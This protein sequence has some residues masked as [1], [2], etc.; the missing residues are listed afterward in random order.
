VSSEPLSGRASTTVEYGNG[1]EQTRRRRAQGHRPPPDARTRTRA[2]NA[3]VAFP[4]NTLVTGSVMGN[5]HPSRHSFCSL[6]PPNDPE[7]VR[8]REAGMERLVR[9]PSRRQ[10]S[11][12][13]IARRYMASD[14]RPDV[15]PSWGRVGRR[16][17]ALPPLY[18]ISRHDVQ[19]CNGKPAQDGVQSK[20]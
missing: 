2:F 19:A 6:P 17:T 12:L 7:R 9:T 18:R 3:P 1:L 4:P 10:K 14:P 11:M 15:F 20:M 13:W 8:T 16:L 5:R